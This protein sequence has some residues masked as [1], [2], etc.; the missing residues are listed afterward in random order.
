MRREF[1]LTEAEYKALVEAARPVPYLI[2][3]GVGPPSPQESAN[4]AWASLGGVH[5]FLPMTIQPVVGKSDR[6]FT[7][8]EREDWARRQAGLGL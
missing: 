8:E 3:N 1:C 5:G 6:Y 4:R 2:F 7:A